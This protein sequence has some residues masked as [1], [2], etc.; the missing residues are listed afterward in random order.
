MVNLLAFLSFFTQW[1][2][3]IS[4]HGLSPLKQFQKKVLKACWGEAKDKGSPRTWKEWIAVFCTV[5]SLTW[6]CNEDWFLAFLIYAGIGCS[7]LAIVNCY[8][9]LSFLVCGIC[10]LSLKSVAEP[11]LSLQMDGNLIELD[12]LFWLGTLFDSFYPFVQIITLRF[13]V[14]RIMLACG[15]VKIF[16]SACW[17]DFTAMC[18][19]YYTQPLPNP[20]SPIFHFLPTWFHKFSTIMTF[21]VEIG[22]P[23]LYFGPAW[24]RLLGLLASMGLLVM[25][26]ISGNYGFLGLM[27]VCITLSLTNDSHWLFFTPATVPPITV[28]QHIIG[29][30]GIAIVLFYNF[31]CLAPLIQSSKYM[32]PP[33][34]LNK[35]HQA[36]KPFRVTNYYGKFGSMRTERYELI[37][38]ATSDC[39]NW[40]EIDFKYKPGRITNQPKWVPF[41]HLPRLDWRTWFLPSLAAKNHDPPDWWSNLLQGILSNN[42]EILSLLDMSKYPF[43]SEERPVKLRTAIFRYNFV[44]PIKHKEDG[45]GD[46][47]AKSDAQKVFWKRELIGFFGHEVTRTEDDSLKII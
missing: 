14:F 29:T 23:F 33:F 45:K 9:K 10:Y 5:P 44:P 37:I 4:S 47:D 32:D 40:K 35:C 31:V 38:L 7:V 19:H 21:F 20:L 8:A 41:G 27:T 39:Q 24:A 34:F 13:H 16:G 18:Y 26:N 2:G 12:F 1:R 28:M 11:F 25:I 22:V 6:F 42:K 46:D 43:T 30:F 17:R 36:L 3:L 15:L